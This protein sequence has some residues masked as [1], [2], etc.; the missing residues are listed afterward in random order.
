MQCVLYAQALFYCFGV[1]SLKCKY[2][3]CQIYQ[4][5]TMLVRTR[6]LLQLLCY[7]LLPQQCYLAIKGNTQKYHGESKY[8]EKGTLNVLL[9]HQSISRSVR[10]TDAKA[11]Y[12]Q[13]TSLRG[14]T[15]WRSW[16]LKAILSLKSTLKCKR[17][18]T[19]SLESL[20]TPCKKQI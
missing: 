2:K 17:K 16:H 1:N 14:K 11:D 5:T 15:S 7:Y 4:V 18:Q 8:C 19:H 13:Q 3:N 9:L 10:E 12:S 6:D 20:K